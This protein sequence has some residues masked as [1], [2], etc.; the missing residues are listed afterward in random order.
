[1]KRMA[2]YSAAA[3]FIVL[4]AMMGILYLQPVKV[5]Q[6]QET[7]EKSFI[8][9]TANT[10]E[11]DAE[12]GPELERWYFKQWHQPFGAVLSPELL[13]QMRTEAAALPDESELHNSPELTGWQAI[14]PDR[15][16][17]P[18]SNAYYTG[19]ILDI[20]ITN[21]GNLLIA[22]ASGGLWKVTGSSATPLSDG[23]QD[24]AVSTVAA[25]PGNNDKI[26]IG[27]GEPYVRG[28]S[29]L[30]VTNNGGSIVVK[31]FRI[32]ANPIGSL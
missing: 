24:L 20:Q 10:S 26:Y 14:G 2:L 4:L 17:V 11:A 15:M 31:C 19:R 25:D 21:D 18:G 30:Y 27:T 12:K 16:S 29:G 9:E 7:K 28:G 32:F 3:G 22:A 23:I 8:K 5:D 1:M 6:A 13:H